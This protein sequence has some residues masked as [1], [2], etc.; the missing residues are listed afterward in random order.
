MPLPSTNELTDHSG[1]PGGA[2]SPTSHVTPLRKT[3]MS[4]LGVVAV[5]F[6][7]VAAG[8]F[9]IEEAISS[10]G[11]GLTL[12]LLLIFPFIWSYPLCEMIAELGSLFPT[13]GGIYCWARAAFGEFW[14]WQAG[15]WG[16]ITT[17]LCQAEY[18]VLVVGYLGK[19]FDMSPEVTLVIKICVIVVF[20]VVN[21]IGLKSMEKLETAIM[22]LVVG[23]FAAVTVVGFLNWHYNPFAMPTVIEGDLFHSAGEGIA[24]IIWMYMGYECM[25]NMA[26]ELE[27]PQVIPRAMRI[28]NPIIA[29]SYILPTLAALAAIGEWNAW[30]V[31]QAGGGVG[32]ADVLIQYVGSWA[33][34][35]FVVVAILA[36]C[37]IFCSY[38]AHGSRT[39]FVMAEDNMFPKFMGKIDRRGIPTASI[40]VMGIFTVFTCQFDFATLV[41]ATNPIQFY[42]YLLLVACVVKT[43][44]RYPVDARR[45]MGLAVMPGGTTSLF[46]NSALIAVICLLAIYV[47]GLD[48]FVAGFI[49]LALGLV[50]YIACKVVYKGRYLEDPEAFPLDSRGWLGLGDLGD[51]GTYALLTG[52]MALS[53]TV[54]FYVI[55]HASG[56]AY[57]LSEYGQGFFSSF[58]GMLV[59]CL[60]V[61]VTCIIVGIALRRRAQRNEGERL[62]KLVERRD[63]LLDEEIRAIHGTVP[64]VER[65]FQ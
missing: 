3:K 42:L 50:A 55:E 2:A 38:I 26:G 25:S 22:V 62:A 13:E 7:F 16:A 32:Y 39:F 61:G 31:E 44:K 15:F 34:V 4:T 12:A 59:T 10:C 36:N 11:P 40:V 49:V 20:S 45:R 30:T 6:S 52:L 54:F 60:V 14:G 1:D 29:L 57:Y 58:T 21:I 48:Y 8:A 43:R 33:G 37:S 63:E 35:A 24:I 41:M 53:G 47:N 64:R 56:A 18:V 51:I 46:V 65:S 5:I 23:A 27:D 28:A 9:G 17:W 19:L